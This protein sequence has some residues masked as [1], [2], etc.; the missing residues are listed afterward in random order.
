MQ[1]EVYEFISSKNNDTIVEWKTCTVSGKQFAIF[2][3]DLDFYDKISP[4]FNEK[5]Y[6]I[7]TPTLCPE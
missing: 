7:P 2:K 4:I 3:S 6:S 1:K 5:K